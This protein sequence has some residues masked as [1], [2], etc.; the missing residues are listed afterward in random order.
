MAKVI[1]KQPA[2]TI[3]TLELTQKE[4]NTFVKLLGD[5]TASK[6]EG[7]TDGFNKNQLLSFEEADDLFCNLCSESTY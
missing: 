3:Y 6:Y 5:L 1:S 2:E 4:Y 7:I